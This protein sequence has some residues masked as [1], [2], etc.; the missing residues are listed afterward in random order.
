[1]K[2]HNQEIE[3]NGFIQEK[4]NGTNIIKDILALKKEKNAVILGHF[5]QIPEIQDIVDFIGDSL[6]LSQKAASTHADMIVFCGVH[7]MAE[8]AKLVAPEKKVILPDANAGCTLANNCPPAEFKKF[9]EKYPD[10][11]V[12][13]YINSSAEIKAMSDIICTS[14]NAVKIIES[15]PKDKKIIFAPDKNLGHYIMQQTSREMVFWDASCEVHD[16]LQLEAIIKLKLKHNDAKLIAHPECRAPILEIADFVGSTTALLSYV[17]KDDCQ[18]FIVAT[19]TGILYQMKKYAPHKEHIIV[20][21]DETCS[22]NDCPYMKLN[23]LE[24]LYI[25]LK[26]EKPEIILNEKIMEEARRPILKMLD[27]SK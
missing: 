20:P 18:K 5:Y 16:V 12:V 25:C 1:M 26:Y 27:I 11:I 22:C 19:E 14:S 23:T 4:Y 2:N 10:H 6:A 15:I 21:T 3:D 8:T 9:K 7:F 24:K 17:E 13:T